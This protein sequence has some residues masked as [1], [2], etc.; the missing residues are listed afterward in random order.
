MSIQRLLHEVHHSFIYN[1]PKL[2]QPKC[3]S[4][5]SPKTCAILMQLNSTQQNKKKITNTCNNV[6]EPYTHFCSTK[7]ASHKRSHCMV[8]F[9]WSS[10]TDEYTYSDKK[11]ISNCL[12]GKAWEDWGKETWGKIE[13]R[14]KM[15]YISIWRVFYCI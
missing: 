4:T 12:G 1:T 2:Q 14:K 10:R 13:R 6:D 15:F 5:E 11:Q 8:S 9:V 7:E 3:H